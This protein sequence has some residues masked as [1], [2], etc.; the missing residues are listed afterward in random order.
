LKHKITSNDPEEKCISLIRK[1]KA[2]ALAAAPLTF[3]KASRG[4]KAFELESRRRL[5]PG[6]KKEVIGYIA[7][8]EGGIFLQMVETSPYATWKNRVNMPFEWTRKKDE[9]SV[10]SI[11]CR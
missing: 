3:R 5:D 4:P 11:H 8:H 9:K 10:Y 1:R 7:K 2:Q 6:L